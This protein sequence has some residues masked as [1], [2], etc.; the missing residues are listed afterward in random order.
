MLKAYIHRLWE[1]VHI[2]H[3]SLESESDLCTHFGSLSL[4]PLS[5]AAERSGR[6]CDRSKERSECLDGVTSS[7]Q[8]KNRNEIKIETNITITTESIAI[9]FWPWKKSRSDLFEEWKWASKRRGAGERMRQKKCTR[10]KAKYCR[11][12]KRMAAVNFSG[13]IRCVCVGWINR[14]LYCLFA[15][16]SFPSFA[17]S[18]FCCFLT[19]SIARVRPPR[20]AHNSNV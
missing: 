14:C 8:N 7:S 13:N 10:A 3:K 16:F 18:W 9:C 6:Q 11:A 2:A 4:S 1:S 19:L 20:G 17:Q 5:I 15:F 12:A